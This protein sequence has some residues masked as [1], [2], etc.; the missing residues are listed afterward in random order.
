MNIVI[1][2]FILAVDARSKRET[3]LSLRLNDKVN[4]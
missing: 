3:V 1:E 4:L 2:L